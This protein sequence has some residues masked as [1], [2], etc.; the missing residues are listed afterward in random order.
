MLE[1]KIWCVASARKKVCVHSMTYYACMLDD[2]ACYLAY[3]CACVRAC[4]VGGLIKLRTFWKVE[5]LQ[6]EVEKAVKCYP[7]KQRSAHRN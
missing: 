2:V 4:K 6:S 5:T 7:W 3:V 1:P